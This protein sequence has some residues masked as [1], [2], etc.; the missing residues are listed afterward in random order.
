MLVG[1]DD[2]MLAVT[3]YQFSCEMLVTLFPTKLWCN[4]TI[5]FSCLVSASRTHMSNQRFRERLPA[6]PYNWRTGELECMSNRNV[7][8]TDSSRHIWNR[9]LGQTFIEFGM[10]HL[11]IIAKQVLNIWRFC[12]LPQ[13]SYGG[14]ARTR[15]PPPPT[16]THTYLVY[17]YRVFHDFRA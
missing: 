10:T 11:L 7:P 6:W 3:S 17:I 5:S 4:Q 16:H 1:L 13:M 2:T 15:P 9:P 14:Q 12:L 8:L